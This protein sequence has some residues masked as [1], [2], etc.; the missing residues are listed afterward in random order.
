MSRRK[1][2]GKG[3][4]TKGDLQ[5]LAIDDSGYLFV[6]NLTGS[7]FLF[8]SSQV[9]EDERKRAKS[10]A[11]LVFQENRERCIRCI[12]ASPYIFPLCNRQVCVCKLLRQS[13]LHPR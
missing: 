4:P 1:E 3:A 10:E 5:A 9:K 13:E 7:D 6:S 11:G 8:I 2:R 12:T